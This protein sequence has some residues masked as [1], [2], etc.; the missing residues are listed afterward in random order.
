MFA[1]CLAHLSEV[2]ACYDLI[3]QGRA[4]QRKQG[5]VQWTSEYPQREHVA[6][7][8]E[9]GRG[10]VLRDESGCIA[11][12]IALTSAENPPTTPS[13]DNG[14][15]RSR[16]ESCTVWPSVPITADKAWAGYFCVNVN[17]F[18]KKKA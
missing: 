10:Y 2:D 7:D 12:Y 18:V 1:L 16:A 14:V 11:G 8:I 9:A 3:E 17:E 4:F 15:P 6:A 5:F 13:K